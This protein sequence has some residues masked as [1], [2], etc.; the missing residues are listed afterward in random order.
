MPISG[1]MD[2][3]LSHKTFLDFFEVVHNKDIVIHLTVWFLTSSDPHQQLLPVGLLRLNL[4]EEIL[5]LKA[6]FFSL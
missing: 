4:E 2:C 1:I 5:Y 3:F 6:D